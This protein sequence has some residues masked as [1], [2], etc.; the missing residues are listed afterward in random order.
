MHEIAELLATKR[1]RRKHE[2][3]IY[4]ENDIFVT[5]NCDASTPPVSRIPSAHFLNKYR[6][7]PLN[8]RV[9]TQLAAS[10]STVAGSRLLQ[11]D[12]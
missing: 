8:R 6:A 11:S 1:V 10:T 4:L 7:P 5:K 9:R 2:C 3:G 12:R